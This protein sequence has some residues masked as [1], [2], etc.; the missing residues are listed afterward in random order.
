M[1][2]K[3]QSA[4]ERKA[5]QREL[6]LAQQKPGFVKKKSAKEPCNGCEEK[7]RIKRVSK[8]DDE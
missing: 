5:R 4:R 3:T 1:A 2:R 6:E 7:K 8:S